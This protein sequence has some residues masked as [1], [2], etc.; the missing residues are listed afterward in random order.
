MNVTHFF[1]VAGMATKDFFVKHGAEICMSVAIG[2]TVATAG[3]AI[4]DTVKATPKYEELKKD[5]KDGKIP[6]SE[7]I[8]TCGPCYIR[9]GSAVAITIGSIIGIKKCDAKTISLLSSAYALEKTKGTKLEEKLKETLG[10][11]EGNKLIDNTKMDIS[12]EAMKKNP[13]SKEMIDT[14]H[15]VGDMLC[16]DCMSGQY[17]YTNS[18][19]LS[20]IE[21]N[22]LSLIITQDQ[23][24]LSRLYDDIKLN[25]T[26]FSLNAYFDRESIMYNGEIFRMETTFGPDGET[27]ILLL[28]YDIFYPDPTGDKIMISGEGY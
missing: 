26:P 23:Y 21:N 2:G 19:K 25:Q 24:E 10:D 14:P 9:T 17:F 20:K 12:K 3:F 28:S 6:L 16:R 13:P 18:S 22:I 7:I 27:P 5:F 1:K 11:K 8:K 15:E 4:A